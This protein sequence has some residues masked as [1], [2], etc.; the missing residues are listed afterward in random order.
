MP[1]NI[2][3]YR[4]HRLLAVLYGLLMLACGLAVFFGTRGAGMSFAASA[5]A[6]SPLVLFFGGIAAAHDYTAQ[7]CRKGKSGGRTASTV[8]ACFM[9]LGFPIGTLIGAYLLYNNSGWP[10]GDEAMTPEAKLDF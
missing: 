7:A 4:V 10:K 8:I 1:P 3:V 5:G 6:V 2:K 9:L